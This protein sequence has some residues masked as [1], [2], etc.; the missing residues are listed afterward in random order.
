MT[1]FL[2]LAAQAAGMSAVAPEEFRGKVSL[3][4]MCLTDEVMPDTGYKELG[5]LRVERGENLPNVA[6]TS[7][8]GRP[9]LFEKGLVT[10]A[11]GGKDGESSRVIAL[12]KGERDGKPADLTITLERKDKYG[13][14]VNLTLTQNGRIR[15]Y[16]CFPDFGVEQPK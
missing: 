13:M 3:H 4:H 15:E 10:E 6:L 1:W 5:L 12:L 9:A 8:G 16:R 7:N 2:L 14:A 11:S